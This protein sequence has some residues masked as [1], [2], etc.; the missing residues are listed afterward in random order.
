MAPGS[1][2]QLALA[3][4]IV[5][6]NLL[7]VLKNS[8]F[9]DDA[10]DW[11][12]FLTSLQMFFTLFGGLLLMTDNPAKPTY[13]FGIMG[14]LL[15]FINSLGFFALAFSLAIMHPKVRA[16]I[17]NRKKTR[18]QEDEWGRSISEA[19]ATKVVPMQGKATAGG[20]DGRVAPKYYL[21]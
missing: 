19:G 5:L 7:I 11:L 13:D 1:S 9:V 6:G 18:L 16:C 20:G 21:G 3:L 10:D 8:P 15:I 4:V 12:A 17:N 2:I 14:S